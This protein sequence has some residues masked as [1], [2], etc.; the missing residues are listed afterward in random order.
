MTAFDRRGAF[1]YDAAIKTAAL[2]ATTA[3][4]TLAGHQSIDGVTTL[5]GDR[6]LV[7]DQ[8]DPK[9]NGIYDASSGNW[10][11][12]ADAARNTSFVLGTLVEVASGAVNAGLMYVQTCDDT[13]VTIGTSEIGFTE[14]SNVATA[15]Q[16]ATSG[17]SLAIG[18]GSKTFAIQAGKSFV[19]DQWVLAYSAADPEDSMLGQITSY[20]GTS[21]IVSMIAAGGSGT[22]TDWIIV[23][24][25]SR[26][27]AGRQPPVGTGNTTGAASSV[28]DHFATFADTT[29][30]VLKDGG[31]AGALSALD[32]LTA[33]FLAGSALG[34]AA[35]MVNGTIA[36]SRAANATTIALKTLA[37]AD[38]AAVDPV[39]AV[40]RNVTPGTGNYVPIAIATA[41]GLTI[42]SGATMGFASATAGRLWLLGL[43]VAG[44]AELAV[45]NCRDGTTNSIYPLAGFGI[46]ST[47]A[48][49]T[50]SD[51]AHVA[52]SA[53]ARSDVPYRVLGYL[54]WESGLTT[55]GTWDA[56][57]TR[58]ELYG[59]GVP[60]PNQV[61][62]TQGNDTGAVATGT[63]VLPFDD[64]I[65]QNTEGDQYLSQAVTASSAANLFD[66]EIQVL[67]ASNT[68]TQQ[69]LAL[70]QDS[71]A[72]AL[73]ANAEVH[74]TASQTMG[75][76][77]RK[78]VL[79]GTVL[80]TTFKGR[81]GN[82]GAGTTTFNGSAA[83]RR[84]GGVANSF[85][86]VRELMA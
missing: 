83:A 27:A 17:S 56:A 3:N 28:A 69:S 82:T 5:E 24:T 55:A 29:G 40:F 19:A 77:L 13:P 44:A 48:I 8:T 75:I 64:S 84:F 10:T 16:R 11:R 65:P 58:I 71:N 37:G 49:D 61:I 60:L 2:L 54:T 76:T 59:L 43:S 36:E 53:V 15:Q 68:N 73:A 70:F 72:N 18:T 63:T 52:Y 50:A 22:H 51:N 20:G 25:N 23:L 81:S 39:Q 80:E 12:S 26:A 47:T 62:Q 85:I 46:I 1:V 38:P 67:L 35:P 6:V 30:K 66:I 86:N 33:K 7:K 45:I 34:A 78:R 9:L 31:V 41:L 74:A 79:A 57:P 14:Q 42:P 4:I 32:T 21:L